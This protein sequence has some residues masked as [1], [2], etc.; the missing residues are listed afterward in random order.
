LESKLFISIDDLSGELIRSTDVYDVE[1]NTTLNNLTVSKTTL[2]PG[3]ET[4]GHKHDDLDEV[5]LFIQGFGLMEVGDQT[6]LVT[7]GAIVLVPGGEF[8]RVYN[9]SSDDLIFIAVF[10]AYDRKS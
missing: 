5:Y 2:H 3:K 1:D 6:T 10:Q 9:D 4:K 7:E 8:H